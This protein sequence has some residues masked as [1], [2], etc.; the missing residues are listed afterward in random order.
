[1]NACGIWSHTKAETVRIDT[2]GDWRKPHNA[3]SVS[4]AV[5][6]PGTFGGESVHAQEPYP[7]SDFGRA[8]GPEDACWPSGVFS[9]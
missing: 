5:L 4:A 8:L 1:M 9:E 2:G 3:R 7:L 6:E